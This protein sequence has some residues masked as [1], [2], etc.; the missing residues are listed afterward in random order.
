M[1]T[2]ENNAQSA[3][4]L[5]KSGDGIT[6]EAKLYWGVRNI[7]QASLN[8]RMCIE[9]RKGMLER[10]NRNDNVE[11]EDSLIIGETQEITVTLEYCINYTS[12]IDDRPAQCLKTDDHECNYH[13][14]INVT[15]TVRRNHAE[16]W[17]SLQTNIQHDRQ[18]C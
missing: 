4:P 12:L 3:I 17:S 9:G 11:K 13:I 2:K 1:R 7:L 16:D 8:C 15:S 10:M 18:C 14:K 6:D 5:D